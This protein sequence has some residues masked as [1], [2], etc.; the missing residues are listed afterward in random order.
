MSQLRSS[1]IA[2]PASGVGATFGGEPASVI[3]CGHTA[4]AAAPDCANQRQEG[5]IE[6]IGSGISEG[7]TPRATSRQP[8]R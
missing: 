3:T 5:R 2:G 4:Q 7:A 1:W 8:W 6:H